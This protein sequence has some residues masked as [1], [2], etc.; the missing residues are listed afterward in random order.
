MIP[1]R[2]LLL[3]LTLALAILAPPSAHAW[4][5]GH[6][7]IT[8]AAVDAL[9]EWEREMLAPCREK[10]VAEYCLYPDQKDSAPAKP[11]NFT[12]GGRH[13]HYMPLAGPKE[14]RE[15]FTQGASLYLKAILDCLEKGSTEEAAKFLGAFMHILEDAGQPGGHSLEGINGVTFGQLSDILPPP[16]GAHPYYSPDTVFQAVIDHDPGKDFVVAIAGYQPKVL[17]TSLDEITFHL[18]E[19][20]VR[21]VRKGRAAI[22]P[23]YQHW[24]NRQQSEL[25]KTLVPPAEESARACAD[26]A[27]TVLALAKQRVGAD[28]RAALQRVDLTNVEPVE[29]PVFTAFPYRFTPL[30]LNC[31][32][33]KYRK[34]YP[35]EVWMEEGGAR[36]RR[37]FERGF[38]MGLVSVKYFVPK[39][40]Y[41][42]LEVVAGLHA[43]L[44]DDASAALNLAIRLNGRALWESG[45]LGK[46]SAARKVTVPVREGGTLEFSAHRQGT[47]A[48]PNA[49]QPVWGDPVLVRA[50]PGESP[51]A[52]PPAQ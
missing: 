30:V 5:E 6:R 42:Q 31:S 35:L 3:G 7:K 23:A 18:Y 36:A 16:D 25:V 21:V 13:F 47:P 51:V 28:E 45:V 15:Y 17:G 32:L 48:N 2:H 39:D 11:Y 9:P 22:A 52:L 37:K 4:G 1:N 10:L 34:K 19:R 26:L 33:G 29:V 12:V 8:R 46:G 41:S 20:Y 50:P 44:G 49:D 43:T 14:N 40:V 27:H 24:L 38:S